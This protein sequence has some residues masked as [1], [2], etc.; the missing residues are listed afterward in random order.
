MVGL[1]LG[2]LLGIGL[3]SS[4]NECVA[5]RTW[6]AACTSDS[7]MC[8]SSCWMLSWEFRC[9][10][11]CPI[12]QAFPFVAYEP[13]FFAR[14]GMDFSRILSPAL[15]ACDTS[16]THYAQQK[17]KTVSVGRGD[18]FCVKDVNIFFEKSLSHKKSEKEIKKRARPGCSCRHVV[19]ATA[20]YVCKK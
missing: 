5:C 14:L 16:T 17:G 11:R 4:N 9:P 3:A 12:L 1:G 18:V 13:Q 20:G 15:P 6:P 8:P 7:D 10:V 19:D 2:E